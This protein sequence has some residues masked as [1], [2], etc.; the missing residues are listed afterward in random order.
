[1]RRV[2]GQVVID[3]SPFLLLGVCEISGQET[4]KNAPKGVNRG[5]RG[6]F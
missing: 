2:T 6:V 4:L 1:M 3:A 5:D